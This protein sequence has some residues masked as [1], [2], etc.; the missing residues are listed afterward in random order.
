MKVAIL[1][2]GS[3][4]WNPGSLLMKGDWNKTGPYL[5]IEFARISRD[6][7]LTLVLYPDADDVQTMWAYSSCAE[8]D[9]AI[10]NLRQREGT[11]TGWI[12]FISSGKSRSQII[13]PKII[14]RM[15][16]W[17]EEKGLDAVIWTY[18]PSNFKEKT[19]KD[20]NK[21]NVLKYL[22]SL[23]GDKL[24]KAKEY[25]ENSPG[26]IDTKIRLRIE[27]ELGWQRKIDRSLD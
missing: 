20:F 8:L 18:L 12:G 21:D 4:I 11:S 14:N 5:P 15:K 26:Q 6:G 23:K 17:A 27:A 3:L 25:I 16:G 10:E 19:G 9:Q 2:W 22:R 13:A 24:N 1:G 7:R